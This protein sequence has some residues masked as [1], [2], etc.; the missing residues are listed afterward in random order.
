MSNKYK[1]EEEDL[2]ALYNQTLGQFD[3]DRKA[4]KELYS[5]LKDY[6]DHEPHRWGEVG[7]TLGKYAELMVKQTNQVIELVKIAAKAREED[8]ALSDA[9]Y[10]FI[11]D[12]IEQDEEEEEGD[13]S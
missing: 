4:I 7:D 11:N 13:E 3:E 9:D 1:L 6:V 8:S 2:L 12:Q 10:D 5:E